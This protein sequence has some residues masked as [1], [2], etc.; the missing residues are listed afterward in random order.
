MSI[1]DVYKDITEDERGR[2]VTE[3]LIE[4]EN[5]QPFSQNLVLA[6]GNE[7]DPIVQICYNQS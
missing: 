1:V 7:L 4:I 5:K 6:S 2:R 3:M